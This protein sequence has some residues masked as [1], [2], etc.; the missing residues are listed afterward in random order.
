MTLY[1][2]VFVFYCR[3]YKGVMPVIQSKDVATL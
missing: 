3:T 2:Q 1:V